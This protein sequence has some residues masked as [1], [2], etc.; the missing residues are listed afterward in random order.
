MRTENEMYTLILEFAKAHD[1]I[2]AVYMN[3]SRANP[4]VPRDCYQDYDIVYAVTDP[5]TFI[6]DKQW[7]PYFGEIAVMQEPDDSELFEEVVDWQ[8]K[9][10]YLM[11]FQDGNRIDLTFQ[12]VEAA[13][14]KCQSDSLTVVLLDKEGILPLVMAPS[15]RDYY[16]KRPT[17]RMFLECCNEFWWVAPYIAKGLWRGEILYAMDHLNEC[18]RPMLLQMLAW[19]VGE[20]HGFEITVGKNNK[21]LQQYVAE[22][23]WE[24]LLETYPIADEQAIWEALEKTCGLFEEMAQQVAKVFGYRYHA[25]E[26]AGSKAYIFK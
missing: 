17:E 22:A 13:K 18:V 5:M 11:Q 2:K 1:E 19:Q 6:E 25:E 4:N 3:G 26:A 21:Y 20:Q 23:V 12:N 7:I 10:T 16:V 14:E 15:D 8:A 24:R 9:Y